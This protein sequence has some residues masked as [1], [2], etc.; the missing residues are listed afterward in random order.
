MAV[1]D[2][3]PAFEYRLHERWVLKRWR[4]ACGSLGIG[5]V[6]AADEADRPVGVV[7]P[8]VK[9]P[10]HVSIG[11]GT[12]GVDHRPFWTRPAGISHRSFTPVEYTCGFRP[13]MRPTGARAA[14]QVPRGPSQE[15]SPSRGSRAPAGIWFGLAVATDALVADLDAEHAAAF[16][17]AL[18]PAFRWRPARPSPRPSAPATRPDCR[19]RAGGCRGCR[20]SAARW[21]GEV[22][23]R[24][25]TITSSP[26]TSLDRAALLAE[27]GHSRIPRGSIG[28]PRPAHRRRGLLPHREGDLAERFP[29][30]P[31]RWHRR[32]S[33]SVSRGGARP[34]D[35]PPRADELHVEF[36]DFAFHRVSARVRRRAALRVRLRLEPALASIA[37]MQPCP[38]PSPPGVNPSATS[39]AANTPGWT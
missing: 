36:E 31:A 33:R 1:G 22:A 5:R 32:A 35:P 25:S 18:P 39:P 2:H 21:A 15:P 7:H 26:A 12:H 37:A 3:P 4:F 24:V 10:P 30:R 20:A 6:E 14:C 23:A 13:T 9:P 34:R 16:D 19:A 29:A 17:Q 38:P 28:V 8:I 11:S 27:S